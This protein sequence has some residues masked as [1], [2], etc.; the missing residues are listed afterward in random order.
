MPIHSSYVCSK[1]KKYLEKLANYWCEQLEKFTE[2]KNQRS[3]AGIGEGFYIFN[4]DLGTWKH[5]INYTMI[6]A[7]LN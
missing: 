5:H 6:L 1:K 3:Q 2:G 4:V 7:G